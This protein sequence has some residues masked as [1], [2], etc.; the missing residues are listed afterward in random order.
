MI[1]DMVEEFELSCLEIGEE[2]DLSPFRDDKIAEFIYEGLFEFPCIKVDGDFRVLR[3]EYRG[4]SFYQ[5]K[6]DAES[7]FFNNLKVRVEEL[8]GQDNIIIGDPNSFDP[9]KPDRANCKTNVSAKINSFIMFGPNI[10]V[11]K[12]TDDPDKPKKEEIRIKDIA[13][14]WF[15]GSCIVSIRDLLLTDYFNVIN[16]EAEEILVKEINPPKSYFKEYKT[17][18][19]K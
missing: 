7:K 9:Y 5:L 10:P 1:V 6:T 11:W 4:V 14:E 12:L 18:R 13:N 3:N 15:Y 19:R 2:F 17:L 16:L 8:C